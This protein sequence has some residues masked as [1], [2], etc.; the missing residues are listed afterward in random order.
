MAGLNDGIASGQ[1]RAADVNLTGSLITDIMSGANLQVGQTISSAELE[2]GQ[3]GTGSP[4]TLGLSELTDSTAIVGSPNASG[5]IVFGNTF[6]SAPDTI[7]A[8]LDTG[9]SALSIANVTTGSFEATAVTA[10]TYSGN[11]AWIAIGSGSF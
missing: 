7:V 3:L 10:G 1:I 11:V 9:A 6:E 5:Y 2:Y 4:P 8:T